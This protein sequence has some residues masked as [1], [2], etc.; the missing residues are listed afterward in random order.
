MRISRF[1]LP[2]I[3]I[4]GIGL[5][6]GWRYGGWF[7]GDG[8]TLSLY[9]N[10]DI[11]QVDLA[12]NVDGRLL[13]MKVQEGD[14]VTAGQEL[15]SLDPATYQSLYD[16]S[17]ARADAQRAVV[18]KLKA[19]SRPEEIARDKANVA[20][21][22]AVLFNAQ[23]I[24]DR[25]QTLLSQGFSAQQ[26]YEEAQATAR[27]TQNMLEAAQQTLKLSE[28]G[29]RVEDIAAQEAQLRAA[30]ATVAISKERLDHCRLVAPSDGIILSRNVE[31]GAVLLPTTA[32]YTLALTSEIWIRTFLPET[33]LTHVQPG[34]VFTISVDGAPDKQYRAKVGFIS[35]TAEF[36]PKTVE[37]PELRT[38]LVYRLRLKVQGD[39]P[40]LR[41]GMP[42]TLRPEKTVPA[43]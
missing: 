2:I 30:E 35:P 15:A 18:A 11:R 41:Q 27:Q 4:V 31:P 17:V 19:G 36:T 42:V 14:H 20:A 38:Q 7:Q 1:L 24:M 8:G 22:E 21:F 25:R 23:R 37:T 32:V 26:Q 40:D 39:A 13:Q 9:G 16:L 29:P 28:L 33:A 12:F 10:V 6:A 5:A 3:V 34:D 43:S